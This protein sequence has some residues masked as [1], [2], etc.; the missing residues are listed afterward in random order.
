MLQT[1]EVRAILKSQL[2][3]GIPMLNEEANIVKLL[4]SIAAQDDTNYSINQILVVSDGSSDNSAE[5]VKS[6]HMPKVSV[7]EHQTRQ[8][9]SVR[10]IE[11]LEAAKSNIVVLLDADIQLGS[12][13]TLW[14]LI[15]PIV[16]GQVTLTSGRP[17]KVSTGTFV[18]K[19]M[20]VSFFMQDQVKQVLNA[21]NSLYACH[22]RITAMHRNLFSKLALPGIAVGNDAYLY[23]YND[24][25]GY[26]FQF[27]ADAPVLF[28]MPQTLRDYIKQERRFAST[29]AE[30]NIFFGED[31]SKYYKIPL[32]VKLQVL[33]KSIRFHIYLACYII[34]RVAALF[35]PKYTSSTW[36]M[37]ESTKVL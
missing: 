4:S 15:K 21:G 26:N 14:H 1:P 18:D 30:Q 20:D 17:I 32:L 12:K 7:I 22:G 19:V 37:S 5:A 33:A 13:Q 29:P 9:K 8:G 2:D 31:V 10:M 3:I 25:T 11:I 34:F 16:L 24:R 28:K 23:I 35:I 6:L 27:A 36:D